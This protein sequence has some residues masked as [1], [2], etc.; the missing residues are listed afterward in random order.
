MAEEQ[1]RRRKILP[2]LDLVRA[3]SSTAVVLYLVMLLA[4][5]GGGGGGGGGAPVISGLSF[6]PT[7]VYVNSGGGQ[8]L[9]SGS[10]A[11]SGANGGV[12]SVKIDVLDAGGTVISSTTTPVPGG[13]G[14]TSG[15]IQGAVIASTAVVGMYAIRASMTDLAGMV[16]NTLSGNFRVANNPWVAK[17]P[18]PNPRRSFAVATTGGLAYV[19]GGQLMNTGTIPPPDSALVEVYDPANNTWAAGV[20]LPTA[21]RAPVAAVVNGVIYVI[22]GHIPGAPGDTSLVEAFDTG[23]SQWST[24]AAM[25]TPRHSAAAAVVGGQ[26]CVF[27]G[28]ST[29]FDISTTECYDPVANSWSAP[30]PP[31]MPTSR[32]LLGADALGGLAYAVSG[33]AISS[34]IGYLKTVERFDIAGPSWSTMAPLMTARESAAV[35]AASGLLYAFGGDN[36][37]GAIDSAEAFNPA[38]GTWSSKT[39]LPMPLTRLGAVAISGVVYVF[40]QNN[41]LQYTP[42]DD[43]L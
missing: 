12:A 11:F 29:I 6:S 26:I 8:A 42:G 33:F 19:I 17:A 5:C 30:P 2:R 40:E 3:S 37:N 1:N 41:T 28:V 34:S 25:P 15:I 20:A 14:I 32:R 4:G 10:F 24:K 21:R 22:G 31:A 7:A 35:V 36:A 27:G 38:T 18:M 23:T 13:S 9:I 43:I 16:S 39:P